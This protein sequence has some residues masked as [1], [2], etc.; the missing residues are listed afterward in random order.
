MNNSDITTIKKKNDNILTIQKIWKRTLK[1]VTTP[2]IINNYIRIG[3]TKNCIK[4]IT[5]DKLVLFLKEKYNFLVIKTCLNRI[6]YLTRIIYGKQ[7]DITPGSFNTRI[8]MASYLIVYYPNCVFETMEQ[9]EQS[10][11]DISVILIETFDNICFSIKS[12]IQFKDISKTL[13][14]NFVLILFDYLKIFNE[15][16]KL[17][18]IKLTTRIKNALIIL[19]QA[20][21]DIPESDPP[22]SEIRIEFSK[23]IKRLREKMV[24]IAGS[25][26]LNE[27]DIQQNISL[28]ST[29]TST[30]ILIKKSNC[31][32]PK[33]ITNE[34]LA[35]ELLL[36]PNFQL[37]EQYISSKSSYLKQIS[38]S[39][40]T[41]FWD[42]LIDELKL[43][44]PC[45]TRIL[46]VLKEIRDNICDIIDNSNKKS[47]NIMKDIDID[48]I[49]QQIECNLY[50]WDNC[51][52]LINCIINI[53]YSIQCVEQNNKTK[54]TWE[55]ILSRI[56]TSIL[57]DK[58]KF[59]C[60]ALK[61]L[62]YCVNVK[63]ISLAN[64][65]LRLIAPVI[66]HHGVSYEQA[67]FQNKLDNGILTLDRTNDWICK[68]L[69]TEVLSHEIDIDTVIQ[70]NKTSFI[71]IH[72]KALLS[73]ITDSIQINYETCPETLIYDIHHILDFQT[74][75][76]EIVIISIIII[77]C[78]QAL[79]TTQD[80]VNIQ[81]YEK[82]IELF[83]NDN[84]IDIQQTINIIENILIESSLTSSNR[85]ALIHNLNDHIISTNIVNKLLTQRMKIF[86]FKFIINGHCPDDMQFINPIKSLIPR[87]QQLIPQIE[88]LIIVNRNVHIYTY[89]KI[90]NDT[91]IK[92]KET[93]CAAEY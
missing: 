10:L 46:S 90:L 74:K 50:S 35:H 72:T 3:I 61:F 83:I 39:F 64:A 49:K 92:L 6:H 20:E 73:L 5:F 26:I 57:E 28:T 53:I 12:G 29:S 93:I 24:H 36:N 67:K 77:T 89:K 30:S 14:K 55:Q 70:D 62:L 84:E 7:N 45:Y 15:W 2:N 18:E 31:T 52:Q 86:W 1:K 82:I 8:F 75:F 88:N 9:R 32:I 68:N 17:D 33:K 41:A 60:E 37:D 80:V 79:T 47:L 59:L 34:Q 81:V 21:K 42:S 71:H 4:Y 58:P 69:Q 48:Y 65:R 19:Y 54:E 27:F 56:H 25:N 23:Q 66:K 38:E 85:S 40:E 44:T 78:A 11:Y 91:A 13:T 87:I 51:I 16:K 22:D 63:R 76:Q 43:S